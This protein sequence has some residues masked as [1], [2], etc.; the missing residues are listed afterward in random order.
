[1]SPGGGTRF[2]CIGGRAAIA[3]GCKPD[4]RK[5]YVGSNPTRY[6]KLYD[7]EMINR[8]TK[9]KQLEMSPSNAGYK[10]QK[11]LLVSLIQR[12]GLD[13]CFRCH[14]KIEASDITIDHK[15]A[16]LHSDDPKKLFFDLENI[17]FSH[18]RCNS[19]NRRRASSTKNKHGLPGVFFNCNNSVRPW[20]AKICSKGKKTSL[21]SFKTKDEA[22]EA[23]RKA[24]ASS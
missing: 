10:L 2:S 20:R 3:S 6:T 9:T 7:G 22:A 17:G 14:Q 4:V 16:W 23:Y 11:A 19:S 21:G 5:D 12:L 1:M 13:V 8:E 18:S 24:A 15:V